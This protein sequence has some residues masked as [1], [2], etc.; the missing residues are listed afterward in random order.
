MGY[1]NFNTQNITNIKIAQNAKKFDIEILQNEAFLK[2]ITQIS[3]IN[4]GNQDL[5]NIKNIFNSLIEIEENLQLS[6]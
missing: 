2:Q 3:N 6:K 1:E 5:E 4:I